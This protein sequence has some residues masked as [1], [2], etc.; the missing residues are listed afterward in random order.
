MQNTMGETSNHNINFFVRIVYVLNNR[1]ARRNSVVPK[2][3][4]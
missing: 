1:H 2:T 3:D 4:I